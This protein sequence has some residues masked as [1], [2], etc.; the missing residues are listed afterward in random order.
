MCIWQNNIHVYIRAALW[1]VRTTV[2]RRHIAFWRVR[3]RLWRQSDDF[4]F[5]Q[6]RWQFSLTSKSLSEKYN[7]YKS[8]R[9]LYLYI[10]RKRTI[11][12]RANKTTCRMNRTGAASRGRKSDA[13][14]HEMVFVSIQLYNN[15]KYN[16]YGIIL[17]IY[18]P[19]WQYKLNLIAGV[20]SYSGSRS[21]VE[22]GYN[23]F[24]SRSRIYIMEYKC[25]GS[26]SKAV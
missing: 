6:A 20:F 11:N 8:N 24:F 13:R 17:I 23:R 14:K 25:P 21:A 3:S 18:I 7:Y 5:D 16:I 1:Q 4:T 9:Y 12:R 19:T 2:T 22:A 15:I 10:Q 26:I